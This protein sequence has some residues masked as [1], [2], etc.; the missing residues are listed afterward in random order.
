[1]QLESIKV[2]PTM[3]TINDM[4]YTFD[5]EAMR[6]LNDKVMASMFPSSLPI[7][8]PSKLTKVMLPDLSSDIIDFPPLSLSEES[9]KF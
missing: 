7:Q 4:P 5:L 9:N 6:R 1:M 2:N 3:S 8:E